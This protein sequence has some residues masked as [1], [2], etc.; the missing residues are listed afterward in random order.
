V[1]LTEVVDG[2][3]G[4]TS[5][6]LDVDHLAAGEPRVPSRGLEGVP[7]GPQG[8]AGLDNSVTGAEQA[9]EQ[10]APHRGIDGTELLGVEQL[11]T[12]QPGVGPGCGLGHQRQLGVVAGDGD[13]AVGAESDGG[14]VTGE[15]LPQL[16][17]PD[18]ECELGSA[19]STA[20]P[21]QTEVA[22][23]CPARASVRLQV[24]DLEA[25]AAGLEGVHGAEEAA[26][27]DDHPVC[28]HGGDRS[29]GAVECRR[30]ILGPGGVRSGTGW[31]GVPRVAKVG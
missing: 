26:T 19:S 12:A 30:S 31:G 1:A 10:I 21:C 15:L 27:D 2:H 24:D 29:D 25:M 17:G 3:G 8:E 14:G 6:G 23:R 16:P 22:H 4:P 20:D 9:A 13:R 11:E 18:G 5:S 7:E 28:A